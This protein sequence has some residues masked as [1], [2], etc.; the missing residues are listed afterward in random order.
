[1]ESDWKKTTIGE[2]F[3]FTYGKSL[4][5]NKRDSKGLIPVYGSGGISGY[6]SESLVDKQG[7]I[8]GRKGTVGSIIFSRKPFWPI[9]TTFYITASENYDLLFAYYLLQTLR[10]NEMNSDSAVPGLNRDTA[11]SVSFFLPPMSEQKRIADILGTLDEKIELNRQMNATLERMAQALF[12]SWFVDFDPV[13]DNALAAG[14]PI[15]EPLQTRAEIRKALGDQSKSAPEDLQKQFPDRFIPNAE[16]GWMPGGWSVKPLKE[17]GQIV[18]GKTPSKSRPELFGQ[19]IPFIKIPDMHSSVF[20]VE[21]NEKLSLLGAASQTK[22]T[23]PRGSICVSCIATVGKVVITST[24]SQTNQQINSIVP[25]AENLTPYLY[26]YM[27][28][29]EK[30]FHDL[31]SGGSATLNMN[32]SSFSRI[33]VLNPDEY[34]L[35]IYGEVVSPLFSKIE[36]NQN[37]NITLVKLRDTLIPRLLSGELKVPEAES[38]IDKQLAEA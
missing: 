2:L 25:K 8:I 21:S 9:D 12:K 14:N 32:T 31:A 18:C 20:V 22:K 23:I 17:F 4:P 26:F 1:M 15:P 16:L 13:I 28:S 36:S 30:L 27:L 37:E 35:K 38:I 6:H 19:D 29:L 7:I 34:V 3:P 10:L 5:T 11:H 24:E 33:S